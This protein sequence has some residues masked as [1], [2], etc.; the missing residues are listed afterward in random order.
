MLNVDSRLLAEGLQV[1]HSHRH[2]V[3]DEVPNI[4]VVLVL[5]Q[6]VLQ[7]SVDL[8]QLHLLPVLEEEPDLD[9]SAHHWKEILVRECAV[10]PVTAHSLSE[11]SGDL[12]ALVND[13]LQLRLASPTE[14]NAAKVDPALLGQD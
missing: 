7:L 8:V 4:H 14:L 10:L 5:L 13:E 1:L 11:V 9:P 12:S 3:V 6:V 2:D